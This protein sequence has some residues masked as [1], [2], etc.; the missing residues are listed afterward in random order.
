MSTSLGITLHI[1]YIYILFFIMK[2]LLLYVRAASAIH[3]CGVP[4]SEAG[5]NRDVHQGDNGNQ[6]SMDA[7]TLWVIR[8]VVREM[9]EKPGN[10]FF[11]LE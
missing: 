8:L 3:I 6:G 7:N 11:K 1:K 4:N 9:R 5:M 10:Q 2:Y